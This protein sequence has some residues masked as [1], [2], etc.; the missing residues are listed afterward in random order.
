M[1]NKITFMLITPQ[2]YILRTVRPPCLGEAVFF[3]I[4]SDI[5]DRKEEK[6]ER[7]CRNE[8]RTFKCSVRG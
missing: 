7:N 1:E 8:K 3:E 5:L 2:S 4:N 6:N